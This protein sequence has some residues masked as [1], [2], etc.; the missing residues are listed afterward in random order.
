MSARAWPLFGA[1][2]VA[3]ACPSVTR[4]RCCATAQPTTRLTSPDDHLFA[5]PGAPAATPAGGEAI[6]PP[7]FEQG[8]GSVTGQVRGVVASHD[9]R[10][11]EPVP[12]EAAA[13]E[14]A[15]DRRCLADE[16]IAVGA[17]VVR[18]C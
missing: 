16:R 3:V 17:H 5:R 7:G 8:M 9:G 18:A 2:R 12:G 14:E 10:H 13:E 1:P 11:H 4:F 15:R 6:G